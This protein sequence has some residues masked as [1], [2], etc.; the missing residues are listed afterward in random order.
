[1]PCVGADPSLGVLGLLPPLISPTSS[2]PNLAVR[3]V[4]LGLK[5]IKQLPDRMIDRNSI[6]L[7]G[8][9]SGAQLI[10]STSTQCRAPR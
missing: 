9:S 8:H 7:G 1:M 5:A 10:R 6:T 3:D 2:D 4:I